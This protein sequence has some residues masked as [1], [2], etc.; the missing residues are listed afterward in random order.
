MD[1]PAWIP[2][3]P[4]CEI[5]IESHPPSV[6]R[7]EEW[8]P[9]KFGVGVSLLG[10]LTLCDL[11]LPGSVALDHGQCTVEGW[12]YKGKYPGFEATET[13]ARILPTTNLQS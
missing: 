1:D 10:S 13:R 4:T 7:E 3:P 12:I 9:L 6:E 11:V 5:L 8:T 2:H